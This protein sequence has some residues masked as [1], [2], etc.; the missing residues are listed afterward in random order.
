MAC[1]AVDDLKLATD[2]VE[3][4]FANRQLQYDMPSGLRIVSINR[5]IANHKHEIGP[6]WTQ[7]SSELLQTHKLLLLQLNVKTISF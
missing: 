7:T 1:K 4:E 5:V 3:T 6:V 2:V